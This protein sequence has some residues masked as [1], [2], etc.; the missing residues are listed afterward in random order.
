MKYDFKRSIALMLALVLSSVMVT[1]IAESALMDMMANTGTT[2]VFTSDAIPKEA[3]NSILKA[4]VATNDPGNQQPW[5]FAAI[6][7]QDVMNELNK[8]MLAGIAA[9][10]ALESSEAEE[11][12]ENEAQENN[13][14]AESLFGNAPAAIILFENLDTDSVNID[15]D[16]G[17]ACQNMAIAAKTLGY[18]TKIVTPDAAAMNGENHDA[19]CQLLGVNESLCGASILLIGSEDSEASKSAAVAENRNIDEKSV[20]V[21]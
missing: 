2:Q 7:N 8:L 19:I 1:A 6:T 18:G 12:T 3:L 5:Y 4:G 9:D 16:L 20:F 13:P 14:S 21:E 11:T 10:R 17:L 15:F